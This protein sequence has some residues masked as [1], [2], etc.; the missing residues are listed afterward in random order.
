MRAAMRAAVLL[1]AAPLYAR[2]HG[3]DVAAFVRDRRRHLNATDEEGDHSFAG[4]YQCP[5][6]GEAYSA[7]FLCKK[8][9][10]LKHLVPETRLHKG[11]G[12]MEGASNYMFKRN[13]LLKTVDLF[14]F[15]VEHL[16]WYERRLFKD[17]S[18]LRDRSLAR[19]KTQTF[20]RTSQ[21]NPSGQ[22]S[23][24]VVVIMPYYATK[25]GDSGHSAL[26]SRRIYLRKTV[27]SLKPT[28]PHYTVCVA[29]KPDYEYVTDPSNE[30]GFYDVLHYYTLPKPSRLG[31]ATVHTAQQAMLT[32]PKWSRFEYVFYTE[33]DQILHVRD[34]NR[35]LHI[36]SSEVPNHVL[37]HRISPVP[38]RVDMGPQPFDWGNGRVL[39]VA[40]GTKA[41]AEFARNA[42]KKVHRIA[43]VTK[44]S[45]C[46]DRSQC[47]KHRSHW[48]QGG[49]SS[50]ELFQI[51]DP[52][53]GKEETVRD[54]FALVAGEGN[55]LRQQF[56]LCKTHPDRRSMCRGDDAPP[57]PHPVDPNA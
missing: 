35:L 43:D 24:K 30:L 47:V 19:I 18:L 50:V 52:T 5:E 22:S 37:P 3:A 54:S 56:R 17:A 26:E 34:V 10:F 14:D 49:H 38:R 8:A 45:C 31:F 21:V 41:M 51:A 39:G 12:N 27:E 7:A 11:V 9:V 40:A 13:R 57:G 16:S 28:F 48:K 32:N 44:A 1:L 36:A 29:T 53:S 55:F 42:P 20:H 4:T 25:G 6:A 15:F 23:D 46:F 33:S 2:P